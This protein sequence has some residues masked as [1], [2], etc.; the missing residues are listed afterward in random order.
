M[1]KKIHTSII[2]LLCI[3]LVLSSP[4]LTMAQ[5]GYFGPYF[6]DTTSALNSTLDF[7]Q[8]DNSAINGDSNAIILTTSNWSV[9][10]VYNNFQTGIFYYLGHWQVYNETTRAIPYNSGFNV[11]KPTAH[12]T[13]FRHKITE[14]PLYN[15]SDID[16][17]ASNG[18][19][20]AIVFVTHVYSLSD[21]ANIYDT[22]P[23]GV[24]Y[25]PV[26]QK[27][28]IY[29]ER[30]GSIM[31]HKMM[32]NVFVA[33]TTG[34]RAFI[35]TST[36]SNTG[37]DRTLIDHPLLNGNPDAVIIVQHNWNPHG[38]LNGTYDSIPIGVYYN[39]SNWAVYHQDGTDMPAGLS[40]NVLIAGPDINTGI[41]STAAEEM[42]FKIYPN[43]A[44][45][46]LNIR[47][48][49]KE[50]A[51]VSINLYS[52]DGREITRLYEGNQ[53]MG[54]HA[55]QQRTSILEAGTYYCELTAGGHSDHFP[56]VVIR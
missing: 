55:L 26:T 17:P 38:L 8:F 37:G 40:F 21:S 13:A 52:I 3:S 20:N 9:G 5:T 29:N 16:N 18:D 12:G 50:N 19:T 33:D 7:S 43:P 44:I 14:I 39:G 22:V 53:A 36:I 35:H 24:W 31:K 1:K 25:N 42:Q 6:V 41:Q 48:S 45:D 34:G 2:R 23:L 30:P 54:S 46:M 15:F 28:S 4:Y 11:V 27:W 51:D 10:A 56:F 49:L 47:Y 32:F